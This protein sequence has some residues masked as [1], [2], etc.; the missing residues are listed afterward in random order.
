MMA[1]GLRTRVNMG[2]KGIGWTHTPISPSAQDAPD[3]Q[4]QAGGTWSGRHEAQAKEQQQSLRLPT[5]PTT[6]EHGNRVSHRRR[7]EYLY[8]VLEQRSRVRRDLSK[9][10]KY[11]E[12]GEVALC[13][14]EMEC[15]QSPSS[16]RDGR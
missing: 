14:A 16:L 12:G 4:E 6:E 13:S 11:Y 2:S 10:R 8:E 5:P 1:T 15:R 3:K 7:F 9:G